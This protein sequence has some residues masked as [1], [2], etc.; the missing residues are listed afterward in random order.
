[1]DDFVTA[2]MFNREIGK[3]SN[4]VHWLI[5]S[6]PDF[7]KPD[8]VW[9]EPSGLKKRLWKRAVLIKYVERH[10]ERIQGRLQWSKLEKNA[11]RALFWHFF[12]LTT[13]NGARRRLAGQLRDEQIAQ[14]GSAPLACDRLN[15]DYQDFDKSPMSYQR[16]VGVMPLYRAV[17]RPAYNPPRRMGESA[18]NGRFQINVISSTATKCVSNIHSGIEQYKKTILLKEQGKT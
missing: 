1:M 15:I 9:S 17:T 12:H 5:K 14:A 16:P 6:Q 10:E 13:G 7:P 11:K 18:Q 3:S 2:T 4:Y 8:F